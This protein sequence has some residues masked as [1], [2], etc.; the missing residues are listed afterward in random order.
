MTITQGKVEEIA[1][2]NGLSVDVAVRVLREAGLTVIPDVAGRA[3]RPGDTVPTEQL[4]EAD[5]VGEL[6]PDGQV[7]VAKSTVGHR[8][9]FVNQDT[10]YRLAEIVAQGGGT[11]YLHQP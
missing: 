1:V 2:R 7:W 10:W 3:S 8:R 9:K 4:H 11:T 5:L 6:Q